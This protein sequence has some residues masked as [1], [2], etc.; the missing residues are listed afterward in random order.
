MDYTALHE[1]KL[2]D[3]YEL[4]KR[5]VADLRKSS[6]GIGRSTSLARATSGLTLVFPVL[7]T[8][9]LPIDTA[10]M[11]SKAVERKATSMLQMALSA[12]NITNATDAIAHLQKF[13]TNL[14]IDNLTVDKFVDIMD[15]VSEGM[16]FTISEVDKRAIYEDC[17]RNI[18]YYFNDDINPISLNEFNDNGANGSIRVIQE[19]R[20][21]KDDKYN[22]GYN[23]GV[24]DTNDSR[25]ERKFQYQKDKEA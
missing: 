7:C 22:D 8:D 24:Y 5:G 13:H 3:F 21:S 4:I 1:S 16:N 2:V 25:E 9:T 17:K 19:R 11:V 10:A 23:Q 20:T 6:S 12:Y 14:D 18:N 15:T